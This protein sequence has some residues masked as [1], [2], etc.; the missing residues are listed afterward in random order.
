MSTNNS[1]YGYRRENGRVGIRNFVT[2]LPVD[3]ISNAACESVAANIH[4][5]LALPHAYGR[6]QF[7]FEI[8]SVNVW[9]VSSGLLY[10][11]RILSI[12]FPVAQHCLD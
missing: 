8:V 3:D 9:S 5:I 10:R 11:I 6:L 12:A 7:G 1:F 4:G 2:V